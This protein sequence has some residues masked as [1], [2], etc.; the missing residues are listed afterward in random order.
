MRAL[1]WSALLLAGLA[2]QAKAQL[3]VGPVTIVNDVNGVQVA[4]SATSW[5]T[6]NSVG[7]ETV[8]DTRIFADLI[9]LQKKFPHVVDTFAPPADDCANRD[10]DN[11]SSVVSLKSG[12]L[13]PRDDK[14]V[15]FIRGHIDVWSCIAGHSKSEIRWRKKKIGFI[16]LKLPLFHTWKTNAVKSKGGT[17]PF[18]G[19]FPI[20]LV[21]KDNATV[22]LR[23]AKPNMM[24]EGQEISL[25][26]ASLQHAVGDINQKAYNAI[27]SAIDPASLKKALPEELQRLNMTVVS[28]RF[29]DYGGHAI[30]EI[31][32]SARVPGSS[33]TQL[34]QQAAVSPPNRIG[35]ASSVLYSQR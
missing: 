16:K 34:L 28:A 8:V 26:N 17:Q 2:S 9:D 22:A 14:L 13:W 12:A 24:L 11:Q 19:S 6:A 31:N 7:D 15:M 33:I 3:A 25:T 5:S 30:V 23:I 4:V 29:R 32:L 18:R 1:F 10:A 35:N 21:S 20:H 27:Q